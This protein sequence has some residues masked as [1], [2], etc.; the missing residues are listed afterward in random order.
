MSG[1]PQRRLAKSFHFKRKPSLLDSLTHR[2]SEK[3]RSPAFNLGPSA[4]ELEADD[5]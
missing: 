4:E 5:A 2:W 3:I 1:F